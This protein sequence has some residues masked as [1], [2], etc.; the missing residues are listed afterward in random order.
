M[1][2][3]SLND[4][5]WKLFQEWEKNLPEAPT[6]AIGGRHTF[7]FTPTSIGIVVSVR[8]GVTGLEFDLTDYSEW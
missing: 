5:E 7:M 4:K 8:D 6:G 2:K 1:M 3:F